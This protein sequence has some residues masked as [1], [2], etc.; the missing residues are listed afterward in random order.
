[1]EKPICPHCKK[2][3]EHR[4]ICPVL[5]KQK[6]K[7]DTITRKEKE[8]LDR[9]EAEML[10]REI[11]SLKEQHPKVVEYIRTLQA[12]IVNLKDEITHLEEEK[13]RD[14]YGGSYDY[15]ESL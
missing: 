13:M 6:D 2:A 3:I 8:K 5:K 9:L 7:E 15:E 11:D 12:D 14:K 10:K 4:K 1:M